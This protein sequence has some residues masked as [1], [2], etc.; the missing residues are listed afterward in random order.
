M[1][2][3]AQVFGNRRPRQCLMVGASAPGDTCNAPSEQKSSFRIAHCSIF[4]LSKVMVLSA[5]T[6]SGLEG[7]QRPVVPKSSVAR[8]AVAALPANLREFERIEP[9]ELVSRHIW[10]SEAKAT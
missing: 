8:G 1:V 5:L 3:H 7:A 10:R 2:E 9:S 4:T 6:S